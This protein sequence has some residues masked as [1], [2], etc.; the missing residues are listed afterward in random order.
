MMA[1]QI[2]ARIDEDIKPEFESICSDIGISVSAAF[3]I[4]AHAVVNEGGIP[5]KL[6]RAESTGEWQKRNEI[7]LLARL[8]NG[9]GTMFSSDEW[10]ARED[11]N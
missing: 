1:I 7:K 3:N 2:T 9:E 5:F 11:A 6:Q 10:D 4:F 8:K